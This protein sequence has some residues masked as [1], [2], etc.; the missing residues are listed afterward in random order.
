VHNN[1]S[2]NPPPQPYTNSA[3]SP[4]WSFPRSVLQNYRHRL[5]LVNCCTKWL[6]FSLSLSDYRTNKSDFICSDLIFLITRHDTGTKA[7][8][9]WACLRREVFRHG[10]LL[11]LQ[12]HVICRSTMKHIVHRSQ[13]HLGLEKQPHI[14]GPVTVLTATNLSFITPY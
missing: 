9:R 3:V 2:Y 14:L 11:R 6:A 7:I 10:P 4:T 1:Y 8:P 5:L 12:W 13:S